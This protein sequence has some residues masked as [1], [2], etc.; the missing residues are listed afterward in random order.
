[1]RN[2]HRGRF[3]EGLARAQRARGLAANL[4]LNRAGDDIPR[5]RAW[6]SMQAQPGPAPARSARLRRAVSICPAPAWL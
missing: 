4:K 2:L 3:E 1:M 6:M 5:D